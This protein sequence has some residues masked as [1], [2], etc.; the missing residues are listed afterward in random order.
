LISSIIILYLALD[1][2][3]PGS[4]LKAWG[5]GKLSYGQ[6]TTIMYLK[7]SISDFLTL[8]SART[9]DGFFWSSKPSPILMGAACIS[10]ALSTLLATFWPTSYVD[11]QYVVGLGN[12][13]PKAM[14]FYIWL[15]CIF[16]WFVQDAAKVG[17]YWWMEKYNILGIND[18]SNVNAELASKERQS[19]SAVSRSNTWNPMVGDE[20]QGASNKKNLKKPL[21]SH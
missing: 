5:I 2:W 8:F 13:D 15:Y 14:A 6:V 3:N 17:L 10:L 20:E 1:S 12:R 11:G 18:S 16:W 19:G 4:L 21:L 7:V 9:H